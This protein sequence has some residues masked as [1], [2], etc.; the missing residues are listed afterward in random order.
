MIDVSREASLEMLTN[1]TNDVNTPTAT[2]IVSLWQTNS[3]GF[4]AERILNWQRRRATAVAYLSGAAWGG[5]VNA[6]S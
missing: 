6:L 4:R 2:S 5:A 1:P 3:V